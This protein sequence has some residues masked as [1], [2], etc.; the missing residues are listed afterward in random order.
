MPYT[1][2]ANVAPRPKISHSIKCTDEQLALVSFAGETLKRAGFELI[3]ASMQSEA[4]YYRLGDRAGALRVA[5]HRFGHRS[6]GQLLSF[7]VWSCLT[8]AAEPIRSVEAALGTIDTAVGR[9]IMYPHTKIASARPHITRFEYP[10]L[11]E[12]K[13]KRP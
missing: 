11:S 13:E 5:A 2:F 8:F 10:F 6:E 7:Q 4:C 9:Y 3:C 1:C 12:Q